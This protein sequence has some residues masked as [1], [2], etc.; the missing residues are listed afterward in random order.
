MEAMSDILLIMSKPDSKIY[1][2][3]AYHTG[4]VREATTIMLDKALRVAEI[5][6]T[7]LEELNTIMGA[8]IS[9]AVLSRAV[10]PKDIPKVVRAQWMSNEF[11]VARFLGITKMID[12]RF[13]NEGKVVREFKGG[14]LSSQ[15]A[16]EIIHFWADRRVVVGHLLNNK[17]PDIDTMSWSLSGFTQSRMMRQAIAEDTYNLV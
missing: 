4:Q 3:E 14:I 13:P 10:A 12:F 7:R 9:P 15:T 11:W 1:F 5:F 2:H 6:E 8:R 16:E 17:D